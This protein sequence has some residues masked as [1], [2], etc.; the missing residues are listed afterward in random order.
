MLKTK[1]FTIIFTFFVLISLFGT[2]FTP[3]SAFAE[4]E[5]EASAP[6]EPS[7]PVPEPS[8]SDEIS[9]DLPQYNLYNTDELYSEGVFMVNLNTNIVVCSKNPDEKMTPASLTKI[10][11]A[12]VCFEN[13]TDFNQ[14]VEC[15]YVCFDEF[16][17][18]NPN[19]R[20]ASTAGFDTKQENLTYLD[21]LYGLMLPSGCEAAN[22]IA[23]NVAGDID[24]FVDMMNETAEK[25]GC[26]NTHFSNTHGLYDEENYT[27]ARDLYLITRYAL[28]NYPGFRQICEAVSY[29][30]PANKINPDGYTVT[31]TN[32]M[33]K[34]SSPYYYEGVKGVKTGSINEYFQYNGSEWQKV[35][36]RGF[37][38]LVTTCAK[39]DYEYLLV[40]LG[41]PFYD[42]EGKVPTSEYT[43]LD[44]KALY[45]W[46]YSE[47]EYAR[48]IGKNEYIMSAKVDM[49]AETDE[50][51]LVTDGE[52][53]TLLPKMDGAE[54]IVQM[55]KP[56]V[57]EM[58]APVEQGIFA[59]NLQMVMGN[60]VV[61]EIPLVTARYV[62]VDQGE[63]YRRKI[64][65]I[66]SSP[67]FI[68]VCAVIVVLV[69]L[70]IVLNIVFR[71]RNSKN[72]RSK[73]KIVATSS[74]G[75]KPSVPKAK[76]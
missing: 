52:F 64:E 6:S 2:T 49:G 53:F 62:A 73:K 20:G 37:R 57:A 43:Y 38:T 54:S 15:P 71:T 24:I 12:L 1:K 66:V 40:T 30:M 44:H 34:S 70:I 4:S 11:T 17:G 72:F 18:D 59:A 31:P 26:K 65:S 33:M 22:I 21:C 5:S 63:F 14:K 39:G 28:D 27:S 75:S 51:G 50:V 19:Y 8:A 45:D 61:S 48:V 32:K 56:E 10:M 46:A 29:D 7:E 36:S 3:M 41:A 68:A 55:I 35:E 25:L 47:F 9:G 74:K 58:T 16:W 76:K 42:E 69:I 23:Y 60:K 67:V 13:V